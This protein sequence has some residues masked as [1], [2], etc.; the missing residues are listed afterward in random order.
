VS[1]GHQ[2][3]IFRSSRTD[4]VPLG[5]SRAFIFSGFDDIET[6]F[7]EFWSFLSKKQ[8]DE[9]S[10][11]RAFQPFDVHVYKFQRV[12][13]RLK[14]DKE[15]VS[16]NRLS[17]DLEPVFNEYMG[18]ITADSTNEKLRQLYVN[19]VAL[20]EVLRAIENRL[21]I[22]LSATLLD[23]GQVIQYVEPSA[24]TKGIEIEPPKAPSTPAQK[25]SASSLGPR[26]IW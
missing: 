3:E 10:L 8:V 18:E 7:I 9:N 26:G 16:R 13:D 24:A 6:R 23:S 2:W 12:T 11:G 17:F 20:G 19:S 1:N 4:G 21:S 25:R 5:Q 14:S 22:T 15:T